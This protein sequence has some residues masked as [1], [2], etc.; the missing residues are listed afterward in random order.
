MG[1]FL[2]KRIK[3]APGVR[4]NIGRTTGS[5]SVGVPGAGFNTKVYGRRRK[6]RAAQDDRQPLTAVNTRSPRAAGG[7]MQTIA[8]VL[9]WLFLLPAAFFGIGA[10]IA[11]SSDPASRDWMVAA[12]LSAFLVVVSLW[13]FSKSRAAACIVEE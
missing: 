10:L 9:A 3:I 13:L 6:S 2:R 1:F 4:I 5:L 11:R 8:R 7:F 12:G